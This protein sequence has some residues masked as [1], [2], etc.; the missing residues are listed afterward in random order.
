MI[1]DY[2]IYYLQGL[3]KVVDGIIFVTDNPIL[4]L[5]L[6]KI[7]DLVIY[8]QCERHE[9]YDFGS[10]KRGYLWAQK[11]GLLDDADELVLCN[12]SCYGPVYPFEHMFEEMRKRKCDFWG[13]C[14]NIEISPHIQSY[15][16]V[17]KPQVFRSKVFTNF[18][19]N[20]RRQNT[21]QEV[22]IKYEVGL[23]SVLF[24]QGFV[25]DTYLE[26]DG[27]NSI[28]S[29]NQTVFPIKMMKNKSPLVKVKAL[30]D[31]ECNYDGI[32]DTIH[33]LKKENFDLYLILQGLGNIKDLVGRH[34]IISFDIF[35]T[36]LL[37]PYVKPTDL[38][39][40]LE[41]IKHSVGFAKARVSAEQ[42]ARKKHSDVE[43]I[44]IDEIYECI[45]VKY[46]NLMQ[47]EMDL[48][49][50][51]LYPNFVIK[52]IFDY[53]KSQGKKIIAISDMYLPEQFLSSVLKAKGFEGIEK[54]YISS[55]YRK[56][57]CTGRLFEFVIKDLNTSA[58]D[59]LHIGD[60]EISDKVNAELLGID[61]YL[62]PKVIETLLVENK[63]AALFYENNPENLEVSIIL[64]MLAL[65]NMHKSYW[66]DFG[67]KYAGPIILGYMKWLETQLLIDKITE[68]MFVARD[69]YTLQKVFDI[70]TMSKFSTHYFYAPRSLNL[71]CNLNYKNN[72]ALGEF[73]GLQ[74]IKTI[75]HYYKDKI[76]LDVPEIS[77]TT[78]GIN[79]IENNK[80]LFERLAKKER[81]SY[82]KYFEQFNLREKKV[83]M[84]DT[85]STLLSAQKSMIAALPD[86][87]V[88]GYYWYTDSC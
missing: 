9:E 3:K 38:F 21:V 87:Y 75:L 12:D 86:K 30:N 36:L 22:I 68:V 10:Y 29:H 23:S 44:T 32:D 85:C 14:K 50:Q 33:Y 18:I 26:Y 47:D 53:A 1:A 13:V 2:V 74:G 76:Q 66:Y 52:K 65:N 82:A 4:P 43:D 49:Y 70:I 57:K 59:I 45:D 37:R 25:G 78:D 77:N 79:F 60:N 83:A 80:E 40:H 61:T 46:K 64:G 48:E 28:L 19:R 7:K 35:D 15:F 72:C 88:K 54:I 55:T 62:C 51:V 31:Y 8:A 73:Q 39:L 24:Q 17:F 11:K 56:T 63:R 34:K 16:L 69:G 20:I 58:A 84:V 67:Y 81:V 71:F 6:E 41:E 42:E 5:E 27:E